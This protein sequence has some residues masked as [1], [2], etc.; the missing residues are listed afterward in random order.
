M[1]P[2]SQRMA[3][4]H[5]PTVVELKSFISVRSWTIIVLFSNT[6]GA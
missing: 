3:E 1:G 5:F 2:V 6:W 4:Q